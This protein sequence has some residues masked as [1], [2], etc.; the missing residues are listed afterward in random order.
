VVVEVTG[1][2]N[3]SK[4]QAYLTSISRSGIVKIKFSENIRTFSNESQEINSQV[5]DLKIVRED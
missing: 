4:L 1:G 3:N 5:L 2:L